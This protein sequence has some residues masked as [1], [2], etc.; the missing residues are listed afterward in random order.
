MKRGGFRLTKWL[1]NSKFVINKTSQS[2]RATS[3]EILKSNTALPTD[4]SLGIIRDLN[5]NAI[6]YKV[7]LKE[8]PLT[9]RGITSTISSIFDTLG[10]IAPIILK[11][12]ISLQ[13][14]SKQ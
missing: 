12:K 7:K 8:K 4:R 2:E 14:I 11:G 13:D 5:D 1:S 10:L 9:R 3:V 6:K